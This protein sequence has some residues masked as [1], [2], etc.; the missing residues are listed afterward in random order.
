[1]IDSF[2]YA[3][4]V[5]D[6]GNG[7]MPAVVTGAGYAMTGNNWWAGVYGSLPGT[8][9]PSSHGGVRN[10]AQNGGDGSEISIRR[11]LPA[12]NNITSY[13]TSHPTVS[14]WVYTRGP[15][16]GSSNLTFELRTGNNGATAWT[17][18]QFSVTR[19][20]AG[21]AGVYPDSGDRDSGWTNIRIPLANFRNAGNAQLTAQGTVTIT[22]W[23]LFTNQTGVNMFIS[24]I[25][26]I[27]E[28]VQ[29]R[30]LVQGSIT[31]SGS[32]TLS[33]PASAY[34]GNIVTITA[35]PS[36]GRRL[37][38]ITTNP[39][40]TLNGTGNIRTFTMPAGSGN[41]TISAVFEDIPTQGIPQIGENVPGKGILVWSDEFNG[42]SLDT[43]KWNI[44]IGNGSQYGISGWGNQEAQSYQASNVIVR[45]GALVLES[46]I[47][48]VGGYNYTSG[49]ITTGQV[50]VNNNW[51]AEKY[52]V[53]T[54][55]VEARIKSSY[56]NGFWPAFWLLGSNSYGAVR[57]HAQQGWPLCAEID[58][59]E[60]FG[61]SE[62]QLLQTLHYGQTFDGANPWRYTSWYTTPG[63]GTTG[64]SQGNFPGPGYAS[65]WHVYGVRWDNVG[66]EFLLNDVRTVYRTW[67]Q[68]DNRAG[69]SAWM[70]SFYNDA[71]FSIILNLAIGGN[72]GAGLP[73]NSAFTD[74]TGRHTFQV[75]WVRVYE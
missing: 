67:A 75:D 4:A 26:L 71:G 39:A 24:T 10:G 35:T 15:G 31:P 55:R 44:E 51:V 56:G 50:R 74:G 69:A 59:L 52:T 30:N 43:T 68:I 33:F 18:P 73:P 5:N 70:Q 63:G 66:I 21:G 64:N 14:L 53:R 27:S 40:I 54:G 28:V 8:G 23:R 60:F 13:L 45:D 65:D 20:L 9:N 1:V 2:D 29:Q 37:V 3:P 46:R 61:G 16:T 38:S 47:E 19:S 22:G 72:M 48:N 58:I 36:S 7:A 32:G 62:G 49:R 34:V 57:G 17:A 25:E 42:N 41:I 12:A 11:T 6:G